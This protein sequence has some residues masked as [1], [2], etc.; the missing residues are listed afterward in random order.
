MRRKCKP[1]PPVIILGSVRSLTDQMDDLGERRGKIR[2]EIFDSLR[3]G[4]RNDSNTF[5]HS[6]G[7]IPADK[8]CS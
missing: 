2:R 5:L 1:F 8:D 4:C 3:P 6:F 7:T